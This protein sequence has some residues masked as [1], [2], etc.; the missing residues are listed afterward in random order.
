MKRDRDGNV[1][2]LF[3]V[4]ASLFLFEGQQFVTIV[5]VLLLPRGDFGR[6]PL[7][8]VK[9]GIHRFLFN[10][11]IA[12]FVIFVLLFPCGKFCGKLCRKRCELVEDVDN[13]ALDVNG[14]NGDFDSLHFLFW[15]TKTSCSIR[16]FD[17]LISKFSTSEQVFRKIR[18]K[19]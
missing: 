10:S 12:V 9:N 19:H 4:C 15:Y 18:Q 2:S 1:C 3:F 11:I 17:N 16:G 5:F 14:R 7:G 13:L 6:E 8:D